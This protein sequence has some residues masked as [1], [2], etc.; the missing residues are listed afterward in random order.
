PHLP[1]RH[2][3]ADDARVLSAGLR[4]PIGPVGGRAAAVYDADQAAERGAAAA[5]AD[6]PDRV[7]L[8]ERRVAP[9]VEARDQPAFDRV[10]AAQH[11]SRR[12]EERKLA[13][14]GVSD[15]A[16]TKAG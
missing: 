1:G 5:A 4:I 16:A 10:V 14:A 12:V 9:A 2:G 3:G 13:G 11:F 8:T 15:Q 7:H 6:Q